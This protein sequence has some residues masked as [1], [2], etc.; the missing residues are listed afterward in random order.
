MAANAEFW[1]K[2]I[3]RQ[4]NARKAQ[5]RDYYAY[6]GFNYGRAVELLL[7]DG[8]YTEEHLA[9]CIGYKSRDQ[10]INMRDVGFVPDHIAGEL[11]WGLLKVKYRHAFGENSKEELT[12]LG[13]LIDEHITGG[14]PP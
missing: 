5:G 7:D 8:H 13:L 12:K 11:L 10:I 9:E 2:Q 14:N 1:K 6:A 4:R 3:D